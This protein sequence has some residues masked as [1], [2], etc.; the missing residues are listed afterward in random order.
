MSSKFIGLQLSLTII[1]PKDRTAFSGQPITHFMAVAFHKTRWRSYEQ[2]A[3]RE[4]G[5]SFHFFRC[6]LARGTCLSSASKLAQASFLLY[7]WAHQLVEM[8]SFAKRSHHQTELKS[9]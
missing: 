9:L 5:G 6:R 2:R 7:A 4:C 3:C 1:V 8:I